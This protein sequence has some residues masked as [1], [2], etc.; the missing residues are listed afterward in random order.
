VAAALDVGADAVYVGLRG[1]SRGGARSELEW[2][3]EA[4]LRS[5][6]ARS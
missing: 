6:E 4:R 5:A 2:P 3:E 1:W